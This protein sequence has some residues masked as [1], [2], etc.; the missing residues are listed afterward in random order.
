MSKSNCKIIGII[1]AAGQGKRYGC[2]KIRAEIDGLL[3]AERIISS[4]QQSDIDDYRIIVSQNDFEFAVER[5]GEQQILINPIPDS[6]MLASVKI[7]LQQCLNYDGIIIW[8]VDHPL[9]ETA[10]LKKL[11]AVFQKN[12]DRIVKPEID[13]RGG[14]PIILP[15]AILPTI[16]NDC[17]YTNL[18]EI[19]NQSSLYIHCVK[20]DDR[21]VI[22]NLNT[23]DSLIKNKS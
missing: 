8:P 22:D 14:H 19:I 6:D 2:P 10:T 1:L 18:K 23:V 3:F 12:L 13:G 4:L 9:V 17:Y 20:I 5:F 11:I 16:L 15:N 21:G 7:G